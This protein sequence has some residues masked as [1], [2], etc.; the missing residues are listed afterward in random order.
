MTSQFGAYELHAGL[1]KLHARTHSHTV[2]YVILIAFPRQQ[3]FANAPQ[4]CVIR[5]LP[6]LRILILSCN[7]II[8]YILHYRIFTFAMVFINILVRVSLI[9]PLI[10]R[11]MLGWFLQADVMLYLKSVFV[12]LMKCKS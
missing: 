2:Q 3:C 11:T 7:L 9:I 6:L 5:T 10:C 8:L 4:Y 12:G 1:A